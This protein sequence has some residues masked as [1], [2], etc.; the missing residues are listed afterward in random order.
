MQCF[1]KIKFQYQQHVFH[2]VTYICFSN[3]PSVNLG[4]G[5]D[6]ALHFGMKIP[7]QCTYCIFAE[8]SP[9]LHTYT[10]FHEDNALFLNFPSPVAETATQT[11]EL[12]LNLMLW[13]LCSYYSSVKHP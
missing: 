9:Y 8:N 6:T 3:V 5:L 2:L 7:F 10:F 11:N 13:L 4:V 1:T 12:Y